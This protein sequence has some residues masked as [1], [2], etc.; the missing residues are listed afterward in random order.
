MGCTV[1]GSMCMR[2]VQSVCRC[3]VCAGEEC[4]AVGSMC[5]ERGV[6]CIVV[7]GMCRRRVKSV[8]RRVVC[9]VRGV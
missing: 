9:A 3:V 4:A 2:G 6:E 8:W 1:V 7:G 5:R